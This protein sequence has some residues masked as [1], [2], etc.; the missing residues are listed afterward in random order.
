MRVDIEERFRPNDESSREDECGVPTKESMR[1]IS[2]T[3]SSLFSESCSD[4][5]FGEESL[6]VSFGELPTQ[7]VFE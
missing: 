1:T 4:L 6:T 5:E 7:L 3:D 2:G